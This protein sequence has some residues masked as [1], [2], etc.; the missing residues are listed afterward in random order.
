MVIEVI[1]YNLKKTKDNTRPGILTKQL[2]DYE[3]QI[4]QHFGANSAPDK[5]NKFPGWTCI[6]LG[7]QFCHDIPYTKRIL[8]ES[9]L[10]NIDVSAELV[11]CSIHPIQ[12]SVF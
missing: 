5:T 4:L 11:G 7:Y 3:G 8:H 12:P 9:E 2:N 1:A 6:S 10:I